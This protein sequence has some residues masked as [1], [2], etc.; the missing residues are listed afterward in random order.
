MKYFFFFITIL[1]IQNTFAQLEVLEKSEFIFKPQNTKFIFI[2]E[3]TPLNQNTFV[4][5]FKVTGVL[6]HILP[7]YFQIK[8]K[9]QHLG[10]NS[11]KF[12]SF[13]KLEKEKTELVV[14][15]YFNSDEF[16]KKNTSNI[17]H[18]KVFI[19]GKLNFPDNKAQSVKINDEIREITSGKYIELTLNEKMNISKGGLMGTHLSLSPKSSESSFFLI[20]SG[21]SVSSAGSGPSGVGLN[22]KTGAIDRLE[23]GLGLILLKIY[24]KN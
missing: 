2:S 10:A 5:T 14:E 9:A 22:F 15:T 4:A 24:E 12:R 11:F 6:K 7:L 19:F 16:F 21:A 17:P 23:D 13:R 1:A 18:N 20:L 8:N 3:E